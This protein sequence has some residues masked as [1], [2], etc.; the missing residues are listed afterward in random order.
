MFLMYNVNWDKFIDNML[1]WFLRKEVIKGYLRALLTPIKNIYSAFIEFIDNRRWI[2]QGSGQVMPLETILNT[3]FYNDPFLNLIFISD[4]EV[5]EWV[6]LFNLAEALDPQYFYNFSEPANSVFIFNSYDP[7][8][9]DFVVNV[10]DSLIFDI[11]YMKSVINRHKLAG[12][13]Y[14]IETYTI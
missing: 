3:I 4:K 14:L 1:P 6:Y 8:E 9:P 10:P 7:S 12:T 11:N 13:S 2:G 5:P